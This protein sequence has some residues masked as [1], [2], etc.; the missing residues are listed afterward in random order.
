MQLVVIA[1]CVTCTCT[2]H[3]TLTQLCNKGLWSL[4]TLMQI[5]NVLCGVLVSLSSHLD[6]TSGSHYM[7][8]RLS[9]WVMYY[10]SKH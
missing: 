6:G 8:G 2:N 9:G 5:Y 1:V 4:I 3:V 7:R 10:I